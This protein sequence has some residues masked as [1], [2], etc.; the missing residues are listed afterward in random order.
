V[1]T[2]YS[3]RVR[4]LAE[5]VATAFLL[6]AVVGSGIAA[7]RLAGGNAAIALLANALATSAALFVLIVTVGPISG[8]HMNPA[9]TLTAAS[10]GGFAWKAVPV[11]LAAQIIGAIAGT[12]IAHA[13]FELPILQASTHVRTGG[14]QWLAELVAT[15]GLLGVIWRCH[16]YATPV[17][18]AAVA[19]YI[20]GAY[21][22]TASTSF[23]NPAVTL[24]RA[25]TDTFSGIRPM[26]VPGFIA[27]QLI[28][29]GIA[30]VVL[31]ATLPCKKF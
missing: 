4:A 2:A 22:F 15:L 23:A 11:Y 16:S 18:A 14:A 6:I 1:S 9:V 21:W 24:A 30:I 25:L 28:A 27:A 8:A 26:D 5:F 19:L 29:A 12:W 7:E 3:L 13:M 17:A 10:V 20:G 31:R